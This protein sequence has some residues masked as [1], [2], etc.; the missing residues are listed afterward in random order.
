MEA[1]GTGRLVVDETAGGN[2]PELHVASRVD[3]PV[4]MPEGD[5]LVGGLQ[6]RTLNV[7]VLLAAAFDGIIPVSCVEAGRWGSRRAFSH[8]GSFAP[9]RVRRE[10][11]RSVSDASVRFGERRSDQGAVWASIDDELDRHGVAS[12]TRA[13]HDARD[14]TVHLIEELVG[15]G[16]L[17]GQHGVVVSLGRAVVAADL[18]DRP[19]TLA[20][21]W[22]PIVESVAFDAGHPYPGTPSASA[23]LR[24]LHRIADGPTVETAGMDMGTEFRV[25][26]Q[27]VEAQGLRLD[28]SLVHLSA[29]AA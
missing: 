18:F 14:R 4:L 5:T 22:R 9:R 23:V 10:K 26:T 24:F 12:S 16:P 20:A 27:R 1:L 13:I 29:F 6:N 28:D 2:V 8:G 21:Y 17:P 19:E 7:T 11:T 15:V 3:R 25:R